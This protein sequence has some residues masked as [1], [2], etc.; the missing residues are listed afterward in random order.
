MLTTTLKEIYE[1]ST[2]SHKLE[3]LLKRLGKTYAEAKNDETPLPITTVLDINGIEYA[4]WVLDNCTSG[5]I[6]RLL[7]AD[8][9]ERVLHIFESK[10]PN[11]KRPRKA[12]EVARYPNATSDDLAA[13]RAAEWDAAW[14]AAGA[15]AWVAA[16]DAERAAAWAA[17]AAARAAERDAAWAALAAARAAEWDAERAAE[18]D[19]RVAAWDAERKAQESRLRQYLTHGEAAKDMP[20]P[21]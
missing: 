16:G 9:A 6:C 15:A 20:W 12:I 8:Y 18:W 14:D 3:K 19:A 4:L 2:H 13:E 17:R 11:D 5:Y 10:Y 21:E 1:R 7:K